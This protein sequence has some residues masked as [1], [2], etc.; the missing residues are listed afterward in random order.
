MNTNTERPTIVLVHGAFADSSSWTGV[1]ER[2]QRDGYRTIAVANP[3]R[4]LQSDAAYLRS[5]LEAIDGP[6]VVAGHSYGG[7]VMS[8]AVAGTADVRAL[9]FVASFQLEAGE[10]TGELAAKFPGGELGPALAEVPF[11]VPGGEGTDLSITQEE[12][13]RVFAADVSEDTAALMA[14]IQRPI[15]ANA[16]A[17]AATHAG[18]KDVES[19]SLVTLEDL[20]IPAES[21]RFMSE[22]AGSHTVEVHASHAVTVSH[23]EEVA[24]LIGEAAMSTARPA[25]QLAAR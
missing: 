23:P 5:T 13:H 12:F 7:S 21:M 25:A 15:A 4:G 24:R 8:E 2:L 16:L 10:S 11:A 1:I 17:D 19:W 6:I 20:A 18:W 14:A 3:L 22:R 9:V